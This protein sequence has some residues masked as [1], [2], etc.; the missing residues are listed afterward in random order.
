MRIEA[1]DAVVVFTDPALVDFPRPSLLAAE[2]KLQILALAGKG[3]PRHGDE[4]G[5][6]LMLRMNGMTRDDA[7]IVE[8]PYADD[9]YNDPKMLEPMENPSDL[10][11]QRD[12]KHDLAFRPLEPALEPA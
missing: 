4:Q 6:E 12:H 2:R 8:F 9:W 10:W 1:R 3:S 11:L 7:E 5:I